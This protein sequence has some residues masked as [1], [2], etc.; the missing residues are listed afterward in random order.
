MVIWVNNILECV[1]YCGL[2]WV[3][4]YS[5]YIIG[6]LSKRDFFVHGTA[7]CVTGIDDWNNITC[8][9]ECC[10]GFLFFNKNHYLFISIIIFSNDNIKK[11]FKEN[12]TRLLAKTLF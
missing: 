1:R 9:N 5:R 7:Q 3:D 10:R 4:T 2:F 6:H 11:C 12:W 8:R